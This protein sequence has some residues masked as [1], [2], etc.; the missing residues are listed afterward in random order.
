VR[1]VHDDAVRSVTLSPDDRWLITATAKGTLR[2]F[3]TEGWKEEAC[4]QSGVKDTLFSADSALL[5]VLGE[6][7]VALVATES[8]RTLGDARPEGGVREVGFSPVK[9]TKDVHKLQ[10][11]TTE[12]GCHYFLLFRSEN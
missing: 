4:P 10:I 12:A 6:A 9:R 7:T 8:C 2:K 5:A 1:L 11:A 3:R